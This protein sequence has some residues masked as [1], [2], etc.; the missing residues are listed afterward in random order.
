MAFLDGVP[1]GNI[2]FQSSGET[3]IRTV[4][5][6]GEQKALLTS[7]G[8]AEFVDTDKPIKGYF[9]GNLSGLWRY[10]D[11]KHLW[12]LYAIDQDKNAAVACR[13]ILTRVKDGCFKRPLALPPI[14]EDLSRRDRVRITSF[15]V[16]NLCKE[17]KAF[18]FMVKDMI[19]TS[20]VAVLQEVRHRAP[21]R[22]K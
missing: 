21:K 14:E 7:R 16:L 12:D 5:H 6:N 3:P 8:D 11:S 17:P 18:K 1:K 19:Y 20:D 2:A 9:N 10:I 4:L 22:T 13:G 15:N